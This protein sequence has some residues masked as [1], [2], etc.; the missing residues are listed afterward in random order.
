[1]YPARCAVRTST[2]YS[3]R[4]GPPRA[5]FSSANNADKVMA[6]ASV[7]CAAAVLACGERK[8]DVRVIGGVQSFGCGRGRAL[9]SY[10]SGAAPQAR[11]LKEVPTCPR[12]GCAAARCVRVLTKFIC[13]VRPFDRSHHSMLRKPMSLISPKGAVAVRL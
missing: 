2:N 10:N 5:L 4:A 7:G 6:V 1:M 12:S 11:G 9:P 3:S 8:R 13:T